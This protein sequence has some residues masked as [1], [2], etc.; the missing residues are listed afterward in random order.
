[1]KP[2]I[3]RSLSAVA[4]GLGLLALPFSPARAQAGNEPAR[5][6]TERGLDNL[7]AFARLFG[8]VRFFHP[9]D[10][11]AAADWTSIVRAGV[12]RAEGAADPTELARAL[13]ETFRP[14]APTVQVWPAGR[15]PPLPVA[16]RKP[17]GPA[18]AVAWRHLGLGPGPGGR[19]SIYRSLRVDDQGGSFAEPARVEQVIDAGAF[20]GKKIR[21]RTA[22]RAELP[23]GHHARLDLRI[24]SAEGKKLFE[25][26][27]ADRPLGAQTWGY[28]DLTADVPE[29]AESILLG[30]IL[31]RQGK[32]WIDDAVLGIV[33]GKTTD[34]EQVDNPSFEQGEPGFQPDGWSLPGEAEA[35]G[36]SFTQSADHPNSGRFSGLLASAD[37]KSL[38]QTRPGEPWTADLGAGVTASV[39]LALWADAA[40]TLPHSGAEVPPPS[41]SG[42]ARA[43]RLADVVLAWNV[44]QHF[45]PYF[46]VVQTD[47]PGALRTA[48][49]E[50]A[51]A[52]N[53]A[54]FNDTLKRLVAA[55]HDGH[56]VAASM[57]PAELR[58]PPL[59]WSWIEDQLVVTWAA[60]ESGLHPGDAILRLDGKPARE[61]IEAAE[62]LVSGAT[63]RWRR[64]RTVASLPYGAP[65]S[66][67]KLE[68]QPPGDPDAP[69]RTVTLRRTLPLRGPE[70]V[71]EREQKGRPE[72]I[73]EVRPGIFY[74]DL[75]RVTNGDFLAAVD[76]LA[77]ARGVVFDLRGYPN[78][79]SPLFLQHLTDRPLH[80]AQ[81]QIPVITRPD[82]Q[83]IAWLRSH[84]TLPP[85]APRL[86][87]KIAFL[88]G[89]GAISYA[90]SC[91]GIVEAYKLGALVGGPTAGT[92]GN[93]NFFVLPGGY[94]LVWTGMRVVKNDGSP[95]H[96]V[97]IQPTVPIAP[98][99]RGVAAGRDEVLEK[100]IEVVSG[101]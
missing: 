23:P 63:P 18:R 86:A 31:D 90:E 61:A 64:F 68:V 20:R 35:A 7:V 44:F 62:A 99:R 52:P 22:L 8:V 72:K 70:S 56:G 100:G 49:R 42:D 33:D 60:P 80:S 75:S 15:K 2:S 65:E 1:V 25:D 98:T 54:A 66:E 27:M 79:I 67:L 93:I 34:S 101:G 45:Y 38:V 13:E 3:C 78:A 29:D 4:L 19:P 30:V 48:L 36:W 83:G 21:F 9:S 50:A 87:C 74:V 94:Q 16:L 95:H 85:R 32:V 82:R 58:T 40:G 69:A 89:P 84:W 97:G 47:W 12:Q 43:A 24:D 88:T 96:G 81:W 91:L 10:E 5:P 41:P 59:D 37:P 76:E 71:T 26:E 77:A 14:V 46:D 55:L 53:A 51:V 6:L 92:N 39:P 28:V 73:A 11:A 17:A 57:T